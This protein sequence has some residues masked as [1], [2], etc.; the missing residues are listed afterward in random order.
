MFDFIIKRFKKIVIR[1]LGLMFFLIFLFMIFLYLNYRLK[2]QYP[3]PDKIYSYVEDNKTSIYLNEKNKEFLKEKDIWAIRINKNGKIVESFNKPKEVKNKFD[4]TDVAG[5]TR[6]YLADYPVFT[7]ILKD[8]LI[9][10]AYPKNSLDKFPFNYYNFK[11]LLFNFEMFLV[12]VILFFIFVY[13][14][15]RIDIKNIFKNILPLQ[16]AIDKIYEDDYEKLDENGEL[17]DLALSINKA[18]EKYNNLKKSQSKWIRGVS[19]DVRTPL[20]KISWEL[21]KENKND[22]DTKN[23]QDQVL[24]ISNILEGL[25]LTMS[26]A[27]ID[28]ENFES[29]SPLKVIRKVIVDK[30]NENPEREIVFE[31]RL[32]DPDIKLK[33]DPTLFYRMVEN[34]IKNSLAYTEGKIYLIISNPD[35]QLIIRVL[36]QGC[37]VDEDIIKRINDEDLT[38][39]TRHGLGIFI[40]KQIAELH[41]G[42]FYIENKDQGLDVSFIFDLI[43]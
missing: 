16:E 25:N 38:N 17:R 42:K 33:M 28:K 4:L 35:N 12:F 5:F 37:G 29:K 30:L 39:I 21:N 26:L 2:D 27:N 23:I 6:Y 43:N 19:H 1:I 20:A 24:K 22:L 10:F 15:Y 14:F 8:G 40:S 34:I 11:N 3:N 9:L 18:N 32:R 31:N 13:I 41:D 36:D 7:Y